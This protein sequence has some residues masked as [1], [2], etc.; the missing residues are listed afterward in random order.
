M[1]GVYHVM[2]SACEKNRNDACDL[3]QQICEK[4]IAFTDLCLCK[5]SF[6][7]QI[8][9]V[10]QSKTSTVLHQCARVT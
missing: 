3:Y 1:L 2:P 8:M 9:S 5:H 6:Q 7:D 4:K 10:F